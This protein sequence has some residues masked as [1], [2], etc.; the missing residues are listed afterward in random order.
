MKREAES[1][2]EADDSDEDMI[3]EEKALLVCFY[4]SCSNVSLS[5][6]RICQAKLE[7]IRKARH[8]KDSKRPEKKL[9]TED[10]PFFTPGEVIDL[11]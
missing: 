8:L 1:G 5:L 9:K 3:K 11:T 6:T 2:S 4:I 10:K 7:K